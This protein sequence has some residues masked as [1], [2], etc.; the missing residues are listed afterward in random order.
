MAARNTNQGTLH[1]S[2]WGLCSRMADRSLWM[3]HVRVQSHGLN[4]LQGA[5]QTWIGALLAR[6]KKA[7][8]GAAIRKQMNAQSVKAILPSAQKLCTY[9]RG[10]QVTDERLDSQ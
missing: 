2:V 4:V 10:M 3:S 1:C 7:E 9:S 5:L 8:I 6:L